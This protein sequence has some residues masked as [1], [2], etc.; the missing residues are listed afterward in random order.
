MLRWLRLE[1]LVSYSKYG[2]F[3]E[4]YRHCSSP[5]ALEYV[6]FGDLDYVDEFA[7]EGSSQIVFVQCIL[8]H[9]SERFDFEL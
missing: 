5:T 2:I 8:K 9:I 1:A 6:Q 7:C 3:I 4:K